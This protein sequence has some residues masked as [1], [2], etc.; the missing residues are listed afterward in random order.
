MARVDI[1]VIPVSQAK[2][3]ARMG[4][5]NTLHVIGGIIVG[6]EPITPGIVANSHHVGI[7]RACTAVVFINKVPFKIIGSKINAPG[8]AASDKI[9]PDG[10][11][12][13]GCRY[14]GS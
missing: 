9:P 7:R 12:S 1:I 13:V 8:C 11:Y 3:S 10:A 6:N 4:Y 14:R 2:R 5:I